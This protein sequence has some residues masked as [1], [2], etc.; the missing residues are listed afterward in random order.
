MITYKELMPIKLSHPRS[1]AVLRILPAKQPQSNMA[2]SHRPQVE[3]SEETP[4]PGGNELEKPFLPGGSDN[5]SRLERRDA[6]SFFS[7]D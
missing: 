4:V 6:V 7:R 3:E 5:H 2:S 1:L